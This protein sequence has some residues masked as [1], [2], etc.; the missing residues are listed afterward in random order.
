MPSEDRSKPGSAAGPENQTKKKER[1]Q[2][3]AASAKGKVEAPAQAKPAAQSPTKTTAKREAGRPKRTTVAADADHEPQHPG[4]DA[5]AV[6]KQAEAKKKKRPASRKPVV[7]PSAAEVIVKA[8]ARD[9]PAKD[10][11]PRSGQASVPETRSKPRAV[12][13]APVPTEPEEP[14][15]GVGAEGLPPPLVDGEQVAAIL[16]ADHGDPFSFLG[17]H[18]SG[19]EAVLIVRAFLPNVSAAKV[20]DKG[21]GKPVIELQQVHDEGLFIGQIPG[22]KQ[23]F[24]YRLRVTTVAGDQDIDDPYRFPPLLSDTDV[25]QLAAGEHI[26]SYQVLGAHP[27]EIEGVKGVTFAVWAPNASRVS[28][29]GEF[30]AW[31]GRCHGMRLRRECGVWE[32][33]VPGVS[34][35]TCYKYEIKSAPGTPPRI[36]SDPYTFSAERLPGTA[37]VVHDIDGFAWSD[38]AWMAGRE[39]HHGTDT[40]LSFY[41]VHLGSWQRK[42]EDGGRCLT[43]RE[44]ADALVDYVSGLGFTHIALLP[45]T[46]HTHDATLGYLPSALYAPT[47]RFGTPDDFRSM[48][49]ACHRANIGVVAD[50]VP[51]QL[52]EETYGLTR[53]DGTALYEH[54]DRRDPDWNAPV[55]D[56]RRPEVVNYLLSNALYWLDRFHLDGLRIDSMAKMLYLDYGR[57][58]GEWTPNEHGGNDNLDALAFLR[59]LNDLVRQHHSGALTIAEDSSLRS[60]LT[61]PVRDGGLGFSLRWNSAW[62]YDT[63]RYLG[64][65]PVH[66]KYYQFE[67]INTLGYAFD[68]HFVLPV[69][70]DHVCFGQGSPLSK[71]PGDWWQQVATL[72]AWYALMYALPGKKLL[73]MGTE[74]AQDREW[75]SDISLDWHL[76]AEPMHLGVQRLVRDLN[77]IYG[78]KPA[79][80]ELD[81]DAQGFE[82]IDYADEDSSVIAFIRYSK[83]REKHLVVV[84][85]FTPAVRPD[86][87]IGVPKIGHYKEVLNTDAEAYGGGNV[88]S[89]GGVMAHAHSVHGRVGSVQLTLAPYATVMLELDNKG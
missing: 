84:T 64:R 80:H 44:M 21:T 8:A 87:R 69:S 24:P 83:D 45:V 73:F 78:E 37:S 66:R 3:K 59:R 42:P 57:G 12:P 56:L 9:H 34:T 62:S 86:Y 54:P 4:I 7:P 5:M 19:P 79:L 48:V 11:A 89:G 36:K 50:W 88:G 15:A 77:R 65:H 31:D 13:S 20:V 32:I 70:H 61:K 55:Y 29:V 43:Y 14:I 52:S 49:D 47:S 76:L 41:E 27:A 35:G 33:F 82:W 60:G 46:E 71:L 23:P 67:L 25:K 22:R 2:P 39:Q 72:R 17:M 28:V 6:L 81:F 63:L 51:N 18:H 40:P 38:G 26:T 68:E 16:N 75:N 30:N 53:F 1:R 74:F 10:A 58:D 85:H